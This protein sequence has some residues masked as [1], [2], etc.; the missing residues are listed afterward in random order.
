MVINI[1]NKF[2]RNLFILMGM[3][4]GIACSYFV[5]VRL[6]FDDAYIHARIADNLIKYGQPVFN[7]GSD[8]FKIDSSTGYLLLISSLSAF[9]DTLNAIVYVERISIILSISGLFYLTSLFPS[10]LIKNTIIIICIIPFFLLSAY[11][12][13]E[14]SLSCMFMI[15]AVIFYQRNKDNYFILTISI[16][17]WFRFELTLLLSL[18]LFYYVF[19]QKKI[20]MIIYAFPVIILFLIE[21]ILFGS[22]IP[23][24]AKAKSIAYNFPLNL[25]LKNALS[26]NS[27]S[28]KVGVLLLLSYLFISIKIILR[29]FKIEIFDIFYIFSFGI[30]LAW[31]IGKSLIFPWYFCL[32]FT[33]LALAF[34][35]NNNKTNARLLINS[36]IVS[37]P[38]NYFFIVTILLIFIVAFSFGIK[39][40]RAE[41]GFFTTSKQNA[42]NIRVHKYLQTGKALYSYCPECM[43]V[44][45]E[46]GGLG[47]SFKGKVFDALGL[48]DNNAINFH[49]LKVPEERS[50]YSVGAIPSEYIRFKNPDYVVA[51]SLFF[52][53][54]K[55][56]NIGLQYIQYSCP[57]YTVKK[58]TVFGNNLIILSKNKIPESLLSKMGCYLVN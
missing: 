13:M 22:I 35:L 43:L 56:S 21:L 54:Y 32:F 39:A 16:A 44:T 31:F 57:V 55:K 15:I 28:I 45:S 6:F 25:S 33:S 50:D 41:F 27:G 52:E 2:I 40:M 30:L 24:A 53:S 12:G 19:F 49:P 42:T 11:G 37:I 14:T 51:M 58:R 17:C 10:N 9:I 47:Y 48:A 23:F 36:D 34:M 38:T 26:F 29:K 46:I 5:D 3:I 7:I 8:F 20:R 1:K 4:L 18:I